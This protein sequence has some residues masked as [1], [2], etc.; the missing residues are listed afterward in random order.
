MQQEER[1]PYVVFE[2]KSEE[3]RELS[4]SSG[5]YSVKDVDYAIITPMGSRDRIERRADE[6]LEQ[7]REQSGNGRPGEPARIP[8]GWF[9]HF[10]SAFDHWKKGQDAPVN[11][12][13]VRNWPAASPAQVKILLHAH[14]NC[15]EDLA[16]ANEEVIKRIGMGGRDLKA[17]AQAWLDAS[18]GSGK[19]AEEIN[20]LRVKYESSKLENAELQSKVSKL[21]A[22]LDKLLSEQEA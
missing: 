5:R 3:D 9:T 12:T 4:I 1:P 16:Q 15:V 11:G 22:Q 18:D 2:V 19:V 6:W 14:I 20:A 21:A 7:L 8:S 10:Q 13:S 17:K